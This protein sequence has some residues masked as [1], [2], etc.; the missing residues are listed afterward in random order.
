[1][2]ITRITGIKIIPPTTPNINPNKTDG[3]ER[4]FKIVFTK[5]IQRWAGK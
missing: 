5:K 1:M 2:A 3:S 4:L